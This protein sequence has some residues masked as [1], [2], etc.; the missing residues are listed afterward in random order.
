MDLPGKLGALLR[1]ADPILRAQAVSALAHS[2]AGTAGNFGFN[3]VSDAAFRL[4]S[5]TQQ[6]IT[7]APVKGSLEEAVGHFISLA[8]QQAA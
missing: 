5:V 4:E 7:G 2:V 6:I 1:I 3:E 8:M